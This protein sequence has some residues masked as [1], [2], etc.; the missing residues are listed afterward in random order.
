MSITNI[1]KKTISI[2]ILVLGITFISN[3]S[4]SARTF[5][6]IAYNNHFCNEVHVNNNYYWIINGNIYNSKTYSG[7]KKLIIKH[8]SSAITDGKVL[9]Y[10]KIKNVGIKKNTNKTTKSPQASGNPYMFK[11]KTTIYKINVNKKKKKRKIGTIDKCLTLLTLDKNK[12]YFTELNE[13]IYSMNTQC[14]NLKK[15]KTTKYTSDLPVG[16]GKYIVIFNQKYSAKIGKYVHPI[17]VYNLRTK[18]NRTMLKNVPSNSN[19]V[20]EQN[21]IYYS[22]IK[23]KTTYNSDIMWDITKRSIYIYKYNIKTGK[24]TLVSDEFSYYFESESYLQ[25]S[26]YQIKITANN[27]TFTYDSD[28]DSQEKIK[29]T[30]SW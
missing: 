24:K 2:C 13:K 15:M 21:N 5:Y 1:L 17:Q 30:V 23:D 7:K 20:I 12:I 3:I 11:Y 16:V 9:Y 29:K 8:V 10:A 28:M 27:A 18:K 26:L 25:S 14:K 4:A 6:S 19:V 22:V